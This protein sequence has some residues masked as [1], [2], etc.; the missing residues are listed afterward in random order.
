MRPEMFALRSG[1]VCVNP[2]QVC[3]HPT[4]VCVNPTQV[5]VN[6]TQALVFGHAGR[7]LVRLDVTPLTEAV[8]PQSIRLALW[9]SPTQIDVRPYTIARAS[10]D[11]SL[12]ASSP[13]FG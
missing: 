4:Q 13:P 11:T 6:P 1:Q 2:A 5:C 3:V 8:L 7:Q 9:Q 12:D 10:L